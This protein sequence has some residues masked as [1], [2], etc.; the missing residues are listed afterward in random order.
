MVDRRFEE[1]SPKAPRLDQY[2][3]GRGQGDCQGE[4]WDP[5]TASQI[6]DGR[7]IGYLH[8]RAEAIGDVPLPQPGP[9]GGGDHPPRD[10]YL[11]KERFVR[12]QLIEL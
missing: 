6:R 5:G 12:G 4:P 7:S 11:A 10:R 9:V 2:E 1:R 8:G 3:P